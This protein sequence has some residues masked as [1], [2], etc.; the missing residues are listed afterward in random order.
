MGWGHGVN[1]A[2]IEVLGEELEWV[3]GDELGRGR[4]AFEAVEGLVAGSVGVE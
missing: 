2:S 4:E 1:D 3:G